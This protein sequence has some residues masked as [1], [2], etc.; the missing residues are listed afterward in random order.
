MLLPRG[1]SSDR[2]RRCVYHRWASSEVVHIVSVSIHT[3]GD[4]YHGALWPTSPK[5]DPLFDATFP[6]HLGI[7]THPYCYLGESDWMTQQ[8]FNC[9][10]E[11]NFR[12]RFERTV[13]PL[14]LNSGIPYLDQFQTVEDIIPVIR[15]SYF[16]GFA[17]DYVGRH[18][19]ARTVLLQEKERLSQC[20]QS[21]ARVALSLQRID[22]I[23]N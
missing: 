19:E 2:S 5:I 11:D 4:R 16:L 17:L 20:D 14:L 12:R 10:Y 1:F 8:S 3:H 15:I 13:G 18:E 21:A 22:E 7:T 6:E 23:L 9:R